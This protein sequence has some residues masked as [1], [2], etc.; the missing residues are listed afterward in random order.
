MAGERTLADV[1]LR[2][3]TKTDS[4]EVHSEVDRG[5]KGAK[6]GGIGDREGQLFS[7]SMIDG[8]NKRLKSSDVKAFGSRW[9]AMITAALAIGPAAVPAVAVLGSSI[10]A[11]GAA[12]ASAG[13]AL[14]VFG[15]VTGVAFKEVQTQSK[16]VSD[17][18]DKI[19][20][21][22]EEIK[23]APSG[24]ALEKSLIKSQ[25]KATN[26]LQARLNLLP[27]PL[28]AAVVGFTNAKAAAQ[29]FVDV[30][31]PTVYSFLARAFNLLARALPQLQ[32]LFDA[33]AKGAS[34]LLHAIGGFVDN[35]GLE[36]LVKFLSSRAGPAL[37]GFG[38]IFANLG[39]AMEGIAHAFAGT[40]QGVLNFLVKITGQFA[41]FGQGLETSKGFGKFITFLQDNGPDVVKSLK[42]IAEAA[43]NI[44]K[45]TAPLA[46]VTFAVAEG[47]T[48]I[49][50]AIPQPLLTALIGAF[51]AFNLGLRVA[52]QVAP[53]LTGSMKALNLVMVL[54]GK[55]TAEAAFETKALAFQ[56]KIAAAASAV[57]GGITKSVTFF[58]ELWK[59]SLLRTRIQLVLMRV[60]TLLQSAASAIA[61]VA[62]TVWAGAMT[63]LGVAIRFA[64]GPIGLII[65]AVA[66]LVGG[67][68]YAYKHSETFKKI[69]D[70]VFK[71]VAASASSF[72]NA[73]LKPILKFVADQ[74]THVGAVWTA[75]AAEIDREWE[76]VKGAFRAGTKAIVL[77][78]LD[79]VGKVLDAAVKMFG[80]VPGIGG[81][82]KKAR[83]EFNKFKQGV[84]DSLSGIKDRNITVTAKA[85]ALIAQGLGR[86]D[87]I[88]T[89]LHRASGGPIDGPGTKT[90]DSIP[91]M[92][93][94][95]EHVWTADEVQGAGG[96]DVVASMRAASV[97]KYAA[98]GPVDL[99][100]VKASTSGLPQLRA[101]VAAFNKQ[102][103]AAA[104]AALKKQL[105]SLPATGGGNAPAN[106]SGNAALGR[107]IAAQHG[108]T[109]A[110]W[111]SLYN[112]W[113]G[114]SG[115]NNNAQN[116][117]STAYGI[118]QFLNSTWGGTGI[119][120]TSNPAS[121]IEAGLRYIQGAYGTPANAYSKWL[122]RSPHWYGDGPCSV[123]QRLSAL[124]NEAQR[125]CL[126]RHA[127]LFL[128]EVILRWLLNCGLCV[129]I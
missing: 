17:L 73:F 115:W 78:F 67:L 113:Q 76:I 111:N 60:Q 85:S 12:A 74:F 116:P 34:R 93:S 84:N 126:S 72:W 118:A 51:I 114:E 6:L 47:L 56:Q 103:D 81:K 122:S 8:L 98:G 110:Q 22:N 52:G 44:A 71:F 127:I 80:W 26:E 16:K 53:I 38:K 69:V 37:S 1:F 27:A 14:G 92:L 23:I 9:Q 45:A 50:A 25:A 112:L 54:T 128:L 57:Y 65:I 3:R 13:A 90:S 86:S 36:K 29:G 108:F 48:K 63:A 15:V 87:A 40:G 79:A 24:S 89:T 62:T 123:S 109:G 5:I 106:V 43:I 30:N 28:R 68:I 35:G 46:P 20:L 4:R 49:I 99:I 42:D 94:R 10:I 107:L 19:K 95:G 82:L 124:V 64:T 66:L 75:V 97:Q 121:Q 21:L 39:S 2:V 102:I 70:G 11:I 125:S 61:S 101:S 18:R 83:D 59:N 120:K 33:G 77:F 41:E 117:T 91:A 104:V 119:A 100:S 105:E 129:G 88:A 31:K 96:H 55:R 7:K 32:P 58:Q